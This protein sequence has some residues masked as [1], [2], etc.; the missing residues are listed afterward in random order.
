[1][2]EDYGYINNLPNLRAFGVLTLA[3]YGDVSSI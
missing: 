1:M 3:S 2:W